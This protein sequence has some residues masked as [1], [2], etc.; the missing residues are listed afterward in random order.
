MDPNSNGCSLPGD[1]NKMNWKH[2]GTMSDNNGVKYTITPTQ[3]RPPPPSSPQGEC[4]AVYHWWGYSWDVWGG[5]FA[6]SDHGASK[7][8][9]EDNIKGCG[10]VTAWTFN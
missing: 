5:G 2:G 1:N 9:L 6:N 8:G 3:S 7:G 4:N 10:A